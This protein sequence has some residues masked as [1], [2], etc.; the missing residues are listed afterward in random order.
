MCKDCDEIAISHDGRC[1][2]H[3][4]SSNRVRNYTD[5]PNPTASMFNPIGV[6]I[7]AINTCSR[8]SLFAVEPFACFDNSVTNEGGAELKIIA[9]INK[10]S[11]KAADTAQRARIAGGKITPNC[12]FHVHMSNPL[13]VT[14][15]TGRP[16]FRPVDDNDM[17]RLYPYLLGMQDFFFSI[18]PTSRRDNQY[19][20]SFNDGW[21][22]LADHHCWIARGARTPTI[23]LRIHPGTLNPW[24]VKAWLDVCKHLQKMMHSVL[25]GSPSKEAEEA[26]AGKFL[27]TFKHGSLPYKYLSARLRNKGKLEKFGFKTL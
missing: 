24:K 22:S 6:E 3:F 27:E 20:R 1:R 12:G 17:Q 15:L 8:N 25:D 18:V 11:D 7:E 19:C 13:Q 26:K 21:Y 5:R 10:I 14:T 16:I 2:N 9:N 4:Q 23:E